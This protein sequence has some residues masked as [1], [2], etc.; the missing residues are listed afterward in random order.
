MKIRGFLRVR[1]R[2]VFHRVSMELWK[3]IN[4]GATLA[5]ALNLTGQMQLNQPYQSK[6]R[7]PERNEMES[8]DLRTSETI[9]C[10]VGA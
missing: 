2:G 7:H 5:V 1:G 3:T 4:V 9:S 10:I 6:V 8:R